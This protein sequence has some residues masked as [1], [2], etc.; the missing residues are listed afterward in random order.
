MSDPGVPSY[1][2][3][4]IATGA[5]FPAG[6]G[7]WSSQPNKVAPSI[8]YFLP[9]RV[10]PA[11]EMNYIVNARDTAQAA[12]KTYAASLRTWVNDKKLV[13]HFSYG[14]SDASDTLTSYATF[15]GTGYTGGTL[16]NPGLSLVAGDVIDIAFSGCYKITNGTGGALTTTL[17]LMYGT[18]PTNIPGG[19]K[20]VF[21]SVDAAPIIPATMHGRWIQAADTNLISILAKLSSTAG[22]SQVELVGPFGLQIHVYRTTP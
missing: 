13:E 17:K 9:E 1:T 5:N 8:N 6:T 16:I 12:A 19:C 22:G 10:Q 21:K 2:V 3:P 15:S 14:D 7:A 4:V 11:E 18:I 20:F